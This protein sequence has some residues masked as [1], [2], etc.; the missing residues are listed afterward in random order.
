MTLIDSGQAE[1]TFMR[2][3]KDF[4]NIIS[5]P[6]YVIIPLWLANAIGFNFKTMKIE[7][8]FDSFA[9]D[10]DELSDSAERTRNIVDEG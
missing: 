3:M 7:K 2:V 4:A 5:L 10:D 6:G 9:A 1:P 8:H